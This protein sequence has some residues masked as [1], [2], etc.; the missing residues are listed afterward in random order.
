[1]QHHIPRIAVIPFSPALFPPLQ[2]PAPTA[3]HIPLL[4]G[5]LPHKPIQRITHI[6]PNIPIAILIQTQRATRVLDE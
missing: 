2:S 4:T 3:L 5:V 6:P 1:M